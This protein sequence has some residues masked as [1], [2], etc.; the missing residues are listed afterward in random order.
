MHVVEAFYKQIPFTILNSVSLNQIKISAHL[1][2]DWKQTTHTGSQSAHSWYDGWNQQGYF[3]FQIVPNAV[4]YENL[5][6]SNLP[7]HT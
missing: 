3:Q 7:Q 5:S 2:K 4:V 6:R 1:L